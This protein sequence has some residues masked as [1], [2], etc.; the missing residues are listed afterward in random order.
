MPKGGLTIIRAEQDFR[1]PDVISFQ[2]SAKGWCWYN[3]KTGK[4]RFWGQK[5]RPPRKH[6]RASILAF[7]LANEVHEE[8]PF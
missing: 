7:L 4:L 3:R 1:D 5:P 2:L 8:V 6:E